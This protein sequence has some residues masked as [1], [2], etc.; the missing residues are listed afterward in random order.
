MRERLQKRPGKE[1][2]DQIRTLLFHTLGMAILSE[3]IQITERNQRC[4]S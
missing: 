3:D 1:T 2:A 4:Q